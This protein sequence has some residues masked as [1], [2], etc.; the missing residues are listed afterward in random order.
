MGGRVLRSAVILLVVPALVM[1]T[2]ALPLGLW[3]GWYQWLCAGI[4]LGLTAPAG[5]ATLLAANWFAKLSP[6][7]RVVA[8]FVGTFV[9]LVVG[10]GGGL[11]VFFGSGP[12]FRA[13]PLSYWAWLLAAYLLTLV[14]ETALMVRAAL[15]LA[16]S[17]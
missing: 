2:A 3:R 8:L 15:P 10:F 1:T 13:D 7:G 4:A 14:V 16:K 6:Y 17:N 12:T 11:V 9:R 5:L